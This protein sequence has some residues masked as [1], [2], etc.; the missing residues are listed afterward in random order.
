M[1]HL[2]AFDDFD[3]IVQ[4]QSFPHQQS[5]GSYDSPFRGEAAEDLWKGCQYCSAG[6]QEMHDPHCP[7]NHS[8]NP[9]DWAM[10]SKALGGTPFKADEDFS[11]R[12]NSVQSLLASVD[13][14][15][16]D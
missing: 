12:L 11:H 15:I 14:L 7:T 16:G 3:S 2:G 1:A 5:G 6:P 13:D 9:R 4:S 10:D 8:D